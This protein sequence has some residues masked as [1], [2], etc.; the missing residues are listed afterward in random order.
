MFTINYKRFLYIIFYSSL[1]SLLSMSN[2]QWVGF[3]FRYFQWF[4]F[5][6]YFQSGDSAGGSRNS[7]S[8]PFQ[9]ITPA[10]LA[11]ALASATGKQE[12]DRRKMEEKGGGNKREREW[13]EE[14]IRGRRNMRK[15]RRCI[16]RGRGMR[17]WDRG[18]KRRG[19][20]KVEEEWKGEWKGRGEG[21]ETGEGE[22]QKQDCKYQIV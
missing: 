16:W 19:E 8:V 9:P 15:R 10:Q 11:A 5:L 18:K 4:H 2:L 12:G 22:M 20:Q 13:E 7:G 6:L 3:F 1:H 21:V 17:I 14:E